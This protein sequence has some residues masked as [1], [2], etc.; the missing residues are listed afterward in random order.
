MAPGAIDPDLRRRVRA[1]FT[2]AQIAEICLDVMKWSVQKA[3]VAT[4]IEPAAAEDRLSR[5]TFDE[6]G[7]FRI[8]GPVAAAPAR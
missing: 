2:D 1:S 6:R 4:R 7:R 3:L 5:L 8:G